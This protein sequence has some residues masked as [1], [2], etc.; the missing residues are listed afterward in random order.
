ME[1]KLNDSTAAEG[2]KEKAALDMVGWRLKAGLGML[3]LSVL[4]PLAGVPTVAFL[5][6]S[7]TVS[8]SVTVGLLTAGELL[9]IAAVAV[10]GKSGYL[11]I[12]T[13]VLRFLK[14]YGPAKSV[15]P[16]RYKIGIVMFVSPVLFGWLFPYLENLLFDNVK[17]PLIWVI[18]SDIILLASFFVLG[19]DFWEKIRALFVQKMQVCVCED[20]GKK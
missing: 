2:S 12:R 6:L 7:T 5:G 20:M 19:G 4:L 3:I 9:G 10:M 15:S 18:G 17:I 14:Q 11:Y 8:T 16:I 13:G 1:K